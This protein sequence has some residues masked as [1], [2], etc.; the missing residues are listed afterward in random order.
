MDIM[1]KNYF[2][3][4]LY[5]DMHTQKYMSIFC[6]CPLLTVYKLYPVPSELVMFVLALCRIHDLSLCFIG[7][8]RVY[9]LIGP[10]KFNI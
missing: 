5:I 1:K 9:E 6:C 3:R 8:N 4:F 7:P 10:N 2:F